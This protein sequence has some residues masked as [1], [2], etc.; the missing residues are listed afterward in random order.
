[1]LIPSSTN[2]RVDHLD[3]IPIAFARWNFLL[4]AAKKYNNAATFFLSLKQNNLEG[5][6][7]A[8]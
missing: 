4:Q 3:P 8:P 1:M 2:R 7:G 5:F 6:I